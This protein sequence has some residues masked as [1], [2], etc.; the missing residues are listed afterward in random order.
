MKLKRKLALV[1]AG[2]MAIS[3][4]P[5]TLSA[6]TTNTITKTV[7]A[8]NYSV[9]YENKHAVLQGRDANGSISNMGDHIEKWYNGSD[10]KM[11]FDD[12]STKAGDEFKINLENAEWFFRGGNL[13]NSGNDAIEPY[14]FVTDAYIFNRL[15]AFSNTGADLIDTT[16]GTGKRVKYQSPAVISGDGDIAAAT[17]AVIDM[18]PSSATYSAPTAAFDNSDPSSLLLADALISSDNINYNR[19]YAIVLVKTVDAAAPGDNKYVVAAIDLSPDE[20]VIFDLGTSLYNTTPK[21]GFQDSEYDTLASNNIAWGNDITTHDPTRGVTIWDNSASRLR[22]YR[23]T[24]DF[25]YDL[26][27]GMADL[28]DLNDYDEIGNPAIL[29]R[30]EM[31]YTGTG[32][33]RQALVTLYHAFDSSASQNTA[34]DRDEIILPLII[35]TTGEGDYSVSIEN[36]SSSVTTGTVRVGSQASGRTKATAEN[37][38][39]NRGEFTFDLQINELKAN[40]LRNDAILELRAPAGYVWE[41]PVASM[42]RIAQDTPD[43]KVRLFTEGGLQWANGKRT[44]L[45]SSDFLGESGYGSAVPANGASLTFK[46]RT[47]NVDETVL[48]LTLGSAAIVRSIDTTGSLVITGLNLYLE[49][50]TDTITAGK[51][52][53]VE[54]VDGQAL[55]GNS[56]SYTDQSVLI[57]KAYDYTISMVRVGDKIPTLVSGRYDGAVSGDRDAEYI[58]DAS[59]KAAQV[60]IYENVVDAWWSRRTTTLELPQEVSIMKAKFESLKNFQ[61]PEDITKGGNVGSGVYYNNRKKLNKVTVNNNTLTIAK[62]A[63][64]TTKKAE[65]KLTLWLSIDVEFDNEINLTLTGTALRSDDDADAISV[66]I[67]RA[68]RPVEIVTEVREIKIGYQYTTVADFDI[69]ET[70]V[71]NLQK[72]RKVFVSITDGITTDD[73]VIAPGYSVSVDADSKMEI[74]DIS[75]GNTLRVAGS[76]AGSRLNSGANISFNIKRESSGDTPATISFKNV[77]V[78]SR[79]DVAYSNLSANDER[80]LKIYAWGSAV[81]ANY[82]YL[83]SV[84]NAGYLVGYDYNNLNTVNGNDLF[85]TPGI[86]TNYINVA[87]TVETTD[88]MFT[89]IVK[90]PVGSETILINDAEFT[91]PVAAYVSTASNSTMVPVRFVANALGLDEEAVKWDPANG[92]VTV[93]AGSRI[94]L[95]QIGNTSCMING[96]PSPM[97]SPDGLP[98]AAEITNERAFVPFRALGEAFGIKVSW[99]AATSTAIYNAPTV[100]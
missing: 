10:L 83:Y 15:A 30:M 9:L 95:F 3:A 39:A 81:A 28:D 53:N 51:E 55:L 43:G 72:G 25:R 85:S 21:D 89:N 48:V 70:A 33:V 19:D 46:H 49:D 57:G 80:G 40:S 5:V 64:D 99:D 12:H 82:Y 17:Q 75:T 16:T 77:Q 84:N 41:K 11:V 34:A 45:L 50:D 90:L 37:V 73:V 88:G 78:K 87:T 31:V 42:A 93:D 13:G 26:L 2:V 79:R 20:D 18:L 35:R 59:H 27:A 61:T 100:Q 47:N 63:V 67:A 44:G 74:N 36:H 71:G 60:H 1:L 97:L 94:V 38:I 96:T 7:N 8:P 6:K 56:R 66:T 68:I 91:I 29:Y 98:V 65:F 69:V 24:E 23:F 62:V 52:I 32:Y 14:G 86:S 22:Y 76:D 92:T 4:L 58:V 54:V